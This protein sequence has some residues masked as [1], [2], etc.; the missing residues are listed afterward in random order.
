MLSLTFVWLGVLDG[1][2]SERLDVDGM[3]GRGRS[4]E[5]SK[6]ASSVGSDRFSAEGAFVG[7]TV[8]ET[9]GLR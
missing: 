9:S 8:G 2:C 5:F 3:G 6:G 7:L 4:P 1:G